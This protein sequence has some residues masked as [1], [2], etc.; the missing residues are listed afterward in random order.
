MANHSNSEKYD[1]VVIGSGPNG[2]AAAITIAK[3][4]RSVLVLESKPVWGGGLRSQE[5]TLPGFLHDVCASIHPL[6]VVSPFFRTLNLQ[7]YGLEWIF[8]QLPLAH[9]LDD[10]PPVLLYSSLELTADGMGTDRD[11][12]L[13]LFAPLVKDWENLIAELLKPLGLPRHPLLMM[14]FGPKAMSSAIHLANHSFKGERARAIFAG[15]S[16]H[17]VL[18]LDSWSTAG[19]G[20]MLAI[21]ANAIGWPIVAGGSQKL[22]DALVACLRSY[23]GEIQ[24]N[25]EITS[26]NNIPSARSVLFDLVPKNIAKISG[27]AFPADYRHRLETHEQGPG[28]FKLDWALNAPIP[29]RDADCPSAGTVHVGGSLQEIA[30]AERSVWEGRPARKPFVLVTQPTLFDPGRAP[31]GKHIGWA[32]CHVPNDCTEDMTGRIENQIERFAPGF[33]STIIKRHKMFPSDLQAHNANYI[34]GDI[35][36]GAQGFLRLF[37]KP[38][39]SL[40]AYSTPVPNYFICSSSMPPGAGVHGMCGHLA[41][42]LALKKIG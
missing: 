4:G 3:A 25:V 16:A 17:S 35:V 29:W 22:A 34:G 9:P 36:G 15:N 11:N 32:Y 27:S 42:K 14:K 13:K 31:S 8:P 2:L 37:V 26:L 7:K 24:T 40:S 19:F 10:Q 39:G 12:Y 41:A 33:Q 28:V 18:P 5:L 23:G 21:M 1:A 20:L 6:A 30:A 38:L